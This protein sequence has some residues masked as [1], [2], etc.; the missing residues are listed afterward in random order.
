MMITRDFRNL[1]NSQVPLNFFVTFF[2][3][4]FTERFYGL[5]MTF[6]L[7]LEKSDLEVRLKVKTSQANFIHAFRIDI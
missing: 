2:L 5:K 6:I 4:N 7:V 1:K 3:L